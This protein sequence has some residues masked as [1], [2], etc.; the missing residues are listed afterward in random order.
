VQFFPVFLD[1]RGRRVLVAGGGR[2]GLARAVAVVDA[3]AELLVVDPDP[4][5]AAHAG[6]AGTARART[7]V[8]AFVPEDC[9]GCTLV[10]ACTADAPTN[11]AIVAEAR[12]FG[13]LACVAGAGG[14]P[15]AGA[16]TDSPFPGPA[17]FQVGA[18]L[19]RGDLCLA[20]S[21][22]GSSPALAA[23]ARDAAA[24]VIGQEYARAAELLAS[25]F[26][27]EQAP[28]GSGGV[29]RRT[30]VHDALGGG[31]LELLREGREDEARSLLD[32]VLAR[33]DAADPE[34]R[35]IR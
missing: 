1:L 28:D 32:A 15:N 12:R 11:L 26:R 21:S 34:G 31:L 23:A 17:D 29:Q 22:G 18:I 27:D 2:I 30:A 25:A 13:A 35:C 20:V 10:F 33:T 5:A 7:A 3:G 14:R 4:A 6:L 8:R 24:G 16:V 9:Q 19:R